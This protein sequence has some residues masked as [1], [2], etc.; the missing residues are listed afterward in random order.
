MMKVGD[1]RV[2]VLMGR[3]RMYGHFVVVLFGYPRRGELDGVRDR[4]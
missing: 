3:E 4:V 1:K 2:W